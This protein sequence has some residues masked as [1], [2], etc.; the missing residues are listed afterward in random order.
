MHPLNIAT[1]L[2]TFAVLS[3]SASP[4]ASQADAVKF[5]LVPSVCH[6]FDPRFNTW[7]HLAS[8]SH[9]RTQFSLTPFNGHLYAIGGRNAKGTLLSTE[10]YVPSTNTWQ[11]KANMELSRCC[12]ASAAVD[13]KILVTGG[14]VNN[15]YSR[16]VCS[17]DPSGDS[18]RDRAWMSSP[19][20][21]HCAAT[22]QDHAYVLGGSQ[23]GPRGER[24]DVLPVECY[25]PSTDQWSYT[26]PLP[27]G[28]SMAGV[29]TLNG[30]ILLVGGWN[31][32]GKKYQKGI[33][34][35]NPDLNE[36][37]EEGELPESTVGVSCCT[38]G[39]PHPSSR[40]SRASSVASAT[41]SI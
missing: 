26:A 13:G 41:V 15:A 3:P 10:C 19:R 24:M 27:I 9:K 8:L 33:Q 12:H 34:A 28:L 5:S 1:L 17:Y 32:S 14:Y 16:T 18:W 2:S 31:E 36:W 22:L 29:A 20:G 23:L 40:G 37:L 38:I 25:N 30:Q 4:T 11:A 6:R 21:W 7:L 35:Y 39:L